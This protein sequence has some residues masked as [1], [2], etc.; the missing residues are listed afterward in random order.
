MSGLIPRLRREIAAKTPPRP[1]TDVAPESGP[2]PAEVAYA[3]NA[4][5]VVKD[6]FRWRRTLLTI[7]VAALG[8][9]PLVLWV[10]DLKNRW[11]SLEAG[12]LGRLE[13]QL[14]THGSDR[15]EAR[16]AD[17]DRALALVWPDRELNWTE[18]LTY[19]WTVATGGW[20][21]L[22]FASAF[23]LIAVVL[24]LLGLWFI[25]RKLKKG[26]IVFDRERQAVYA[27]HNRELL[28]SRWQ[29]IHFILR[30]WQFGWLLSDDQGESHLIETRL[31]LDGTW[32][33]ANETGETHVARI[34]AFMAEGPDAL[35][36]VKRASSEAYVTP[37]ILAKL[38]ARLR[39][40]TNSE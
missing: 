8:F 32:A 19:E 14:S 6:T 4:K 40:T 39:D 9:T 13:N 12:L 38:E 29:D 21:A 10:W 1:A 15:V 37:E 22:V 23:V 35:P 11:Q 3:D 16:I 5:L 28:L 17:G 25:A 24:S 36:G 30:P 34:A 31:P 2:V 33:Y 27:I 7:V 26:P 18:F 20:Q